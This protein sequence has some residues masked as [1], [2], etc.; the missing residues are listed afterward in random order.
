MNRYKIYLKSGTVI[1]IHADDVY[2]NSVNNSWLTF[3]NGEAETYE[4]VAQFAPNM[5]EG[6]QKLTLRPAT[7]TEKSGS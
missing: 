3:S 5:W 2:V 6:Y 7:E 4:F 1:T